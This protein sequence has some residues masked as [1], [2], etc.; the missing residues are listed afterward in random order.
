MKDAK[1]PAF[2]LSNRTEKKQYKKQISNRFSERKTPQI[3]FC[4][5]QFLACYYYY[6]YKSRD[7]SDGIMQKNTLQGHFTVNIEM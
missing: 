7:Y 3:P 1:Q 5:A 4:S 2:L 6:Y